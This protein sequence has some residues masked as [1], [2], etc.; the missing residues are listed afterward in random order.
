[1]PSLVNAKTLDSGLR[2]ND[3]GVVTPRNAGVRD[4]SLTRL[5]FA[6]EP[7]HP[8]KNRIEF[9]AARLQK[10]NLPRALLRVVRHTVEFAPP[11]LF[12]CAGSI[13]LRLRQGALDQ[14]RGDAVSLQI[15]LY[16][17]GSV[18][19]R[20]GVGEYRRGTLITEQTLGFKRIEHGAQFITAVGELVL[21]LGAR[22]LAP[23]KIA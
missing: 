18:A 9:E 5:R 8:N 4:N 14:I 3:A 6:F 22:V 11:R 13:G 12:N 7:A 17:T 20:L 21:K 23:R 19:T 16:V 2:R 1:M 10:A 15:M